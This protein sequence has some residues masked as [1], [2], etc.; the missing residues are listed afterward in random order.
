[1]QGDSGVRTARDPPTIKQ[2]LINHLY[3]LE[4]KVDI[5]IRHAVE[6]DL[7]KCHQCLAAVV[8][9]GRWLSRLTPPPLERYSAWWHSMMTVKAPQIVAFD[10]DALIGWCDIALRDNPV[11]SHVGGLGM[12]IIPDYRNRG[13]GKRLLERALDAAKEK[14][15]E[16]IELSVLHDNEP[17]IALYKRM[18]FVTE[19][20]R[21]REWK[22]GNKYRD[23]ILMAIFL[24]AIP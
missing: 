7:H 6:A 16:R 22:V 15:L 13:I 24:T 5:D 12:G 9:E 20:R 8:Q 11:Q 17:A 2:C 4:N 23:S 10:G 1:M 3:L 19:G 14:R 21:E 18:G